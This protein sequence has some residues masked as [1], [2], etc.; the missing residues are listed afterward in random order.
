MRKKPTT[1]TLSPEV[2]EEI[3]ERSVEANISASLWLNLHLIK[4]LDIEVETRKAKRAKDI[5]HEN[6]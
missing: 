1:Y 2:V 5:D 3:F 6:S 4:A